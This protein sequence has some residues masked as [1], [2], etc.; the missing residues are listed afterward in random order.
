MA[1]SP[2]DIEGTEEE[3][4]AGDEGRCMRAAEEGVLDVLAS[5]LS[6]YGPPEDPAL[7]SADGRE[8]SLRRSALKH[9][10]L[11]VLALTFGSVIRAHWAV[12]AGIVRALTTAARRSR[13]PG[14]QP[15]PFLDKIDLARQWLEMQARLLGPR[16]K[17]LDQVPRKP[18]G[19]AHGLADG[20]DS[21]LSA[22]LAWMSALPCWSCHLESALAR[23]MAGMGMSDR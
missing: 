22:T 5:I 17:A 9:A 13:Q 16:S 14:A 1:V 21:G 11:C 10:V 2:R 7:A 15:L 8:R 19:A 20:A 12:Q 4:A 6:T 23:C 18:K 3:S